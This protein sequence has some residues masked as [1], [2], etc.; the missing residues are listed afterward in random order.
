MSNEW[1]RLASEA[2]DRADQGMRAL[3]FYRAAV[4]KLSK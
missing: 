3:S 4:R 2:D 1:K